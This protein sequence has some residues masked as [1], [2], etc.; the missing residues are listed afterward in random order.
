VT[1]H[2]KKDAMQVRG[3]KKNN[4]SKT[5]TKNIIFG[6]MDYLRSKINKKNGL[7][8]MKIRAKQN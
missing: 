5:A 2:V 7:S 3:K 1:S 4:M 6:A 8:E